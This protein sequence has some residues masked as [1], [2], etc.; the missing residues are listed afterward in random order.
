MSP[1]ANGRGIISENYRALT[2]FFL[3]RRAAGYYTHEGINHRWKISYT[4][5]VAFQSNFHP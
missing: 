2:S 5:S 3:R 4:E 1:A